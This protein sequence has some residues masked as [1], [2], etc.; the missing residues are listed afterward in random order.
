LRLFSRHFQALREQRG[1]GERQPDS[2]DA[3][4]PTEAVKHLSE[5]R[6]TDQPAGEIAREI[7]SASRAAVSR[8]GTA[9]E[10]G[11]D[12]LREERADG[13]QNHAEQHGRKARQQQER[14]PDSGERQRYPKRRSRSETSYSLTRQQRAHDRRQEHEIDETELHHSE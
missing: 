5:D 7:D 10:A 2:G 1:H 13:G 8:R 6:S 9:D 3:G 4:R 14:Q 12:R 11:R